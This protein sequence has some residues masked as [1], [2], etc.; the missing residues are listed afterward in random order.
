MMTIGLTCSISQSLQSSY[1]F[2]NQF[3][4][5]HSSLTSIPLTFTTSELLAPYMIAIETL[6]I[7]HQKRLTH[8][9]KPRGHCTNL[10]KHKVTISIYHDVYDVFYPFR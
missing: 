6:A 1:K 3:Y 7:T 4:K 8:R 10:P 5:A 9:E 2:N